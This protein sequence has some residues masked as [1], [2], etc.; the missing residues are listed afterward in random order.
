[1]AIAVNAVVINRQP[2]YWSGDGVPTRVLLSVL[3]FARTEDVQNNAIVGDVRFLK[4]VEFG[5]LPFDVGC[6]VFL[7]DHI[8]VLRAR[9]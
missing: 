1:M 2:F 6:N 5:G 9:G 7:E 3:V 4:L 8:S